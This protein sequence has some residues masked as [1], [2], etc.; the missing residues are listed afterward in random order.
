MMMIIFCKA[1][2]ITR[3]FALSCYKEFLLCYQSGVVQLSLSIYTKLLAIPA[4]F[5]FS[6]RQVFE[7]YHCCLFVFLFRDYKDNN[8]D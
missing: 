6:L 2:D 5:K 4:Q 7:V 3:H 8:K 1:K